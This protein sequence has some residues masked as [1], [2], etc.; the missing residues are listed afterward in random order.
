M[1]VNFSL[2]STTELYSNAI[3]INTHIFT[4][5]LYHKQDVIQGQFFSAEF[6]R[7]ELIIFLLLTGC[8]TKV[9]EPSMSYYLPIIGG[10]M[11]AYIPYRYE[12]YAKCKWP[13]TGFEL[14]SQS[15]FPTMI[16]LCH[17]HLH[18]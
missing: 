3:S 14:K 13:H 7:F 11:D 8:H 10:I 15:P 1:C 9:K 5:P 6:N 16:T 12:P 4:Q 2:L 18:H 17:K